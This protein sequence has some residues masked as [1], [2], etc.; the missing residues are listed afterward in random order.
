MNKDVGVAHGL[1]ARGRCATL[2]QVCKESPRHSCRQTSRL[3]CVHALQHSASADG[4]CTLSRLLGGWLTGPQKTHTAECAAAYV[5]AAASNPCRDHL[6]IFDSL[7]PAD[8]AQKILPI[9]F[10]R[11]TQHWSR[12]SGQQARQKVGLGVAKGD[13]KALKEQ[14][15]RTFG[16]SKTGGEARSN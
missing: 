2:G 6:R 14:G 9:L 4:R 1:F 11:D 15:W 7:S 12:S 10:L 8:A 3:R 5:M 13:K 16:Y